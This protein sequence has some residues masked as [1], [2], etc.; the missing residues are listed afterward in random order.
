MLVFLDG[1]FQ[2]ENRRFQ[3][4][5]LGFLE[6][7]TTNYFSIFPFYNCMWV[8][9]MNSICF[10]LICLENKFNQIPVKKEL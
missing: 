2:F 5:C 6:N 8:R 1:Y 9:V 7:K 10:G 3:C 4:V